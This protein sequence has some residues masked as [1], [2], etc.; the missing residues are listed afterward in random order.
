MRLG[1]VPSSSSG[2]VPEGQLL[3][4]HFKGDVSPFERVF[5]TSD[6]LLSQG[7]FQD[8]AS[9]RTWESRILTTLVDHRLNSYQILNSYLF[10]KMKTT[11]F[12]IVAIVE[13]QVAFLLHL[14]W[15]VG[16]ILH[17]MI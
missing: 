14:E 3:S 15:D 12:E 1:S 8:S 5:P 6:F 16:I 4:Q 11:A 9:E 2:S 10:S 13:R 7:L 17:E